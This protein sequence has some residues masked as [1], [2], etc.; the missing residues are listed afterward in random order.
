MMKS[1]PKLYR[2]FEM[3]PGSLIWIT[4]AVAIILSFIRPLWVL[5]FIVLFDLYWLFRVVYFVFYLSISWR[6]F[7]RDTSSDW[8]SKLKAERPQWEKLYHLIFL[9]TYKEGIEI[10]TTTL[11]S[12]ADSTYPKEKLIIVFAGEER[13]RENFLQNAALIEEK[14]KNVFG[15]FIK[16]IHPA[17]LPDEIPGKGSNLNWAGHRAR[18]F[19]DELKI[20]YEDVIVSSLDIDTIVHPQYFA[21][22]SYQYLTVPNP[23]RASYQPIALYNNN[24]W[25]S[26]ALI[27]IAALGTTFWLMT[28]LPRTERLFT[29]SSHSMPFKALLDVG[30]WQKDIVT[31]DSRIFLQCFLH[32]NGDYRVI[33]LYLP[34]SMDTVTS[35]NYWNSLKA[36]YYQQRRW[37]WGIEHFP[38]MAWNFLKHKQIPL[39]RKIKFLWN[40]GEGMY[41][42]ATAPLLIFLLGKLPFLLGGG[43]FVD[44]VFFQSTP[45][46]LQWLM[47]VAM[48]GMIVSAIL[49]S[50]LLPPRPPGVAFYRA[51]HIFW[52]WLLLPVTLII[53]GSLPAFD[54]QTR[55]LFG[56]YLGFNVTE[57]KRKR[58]QTPEGIQEIVAAN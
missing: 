17:N 55:L 35:G 36:L 54:A 41:S 12:L 23:L 33:P 24:I 15:H 7:R 26:P 8:T 34:V 28:E 3:I 45:F 16:T 44:T 50:R 48:V 30:F 27:R 6:R 40:L 20:P 46:M 39:R 25:D 21:Y 1:K 10:L 53:F 43:H 22:L 58:H 2:F 13:D 31:E 14:F 4:L 32:Y 56:K 52:Q 37:A 9:P 38:Y 42:W 19:I 18:E 49:T 47:R 51:W 11:Q 57:K 5:Y 29:F